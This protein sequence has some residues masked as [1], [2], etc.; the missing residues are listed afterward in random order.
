MV[1][2]MVLKKTN[3]WP[4]L[5]DCFFL[6]L[7]LLCVIFPPLHL[8]GSLSVS[9]LLLLDV[10]G[11]NEVVDGGVHLFLLDEVVSPGLL[12]FHHLGGE[13]EASQLHRYGKQDGQNF[14]KS[15]CCPTSYGRYLYQR[16]NIHLSWRRLLCSNTPELSGC[17]WSARTDL[18]PGWRTH[19]QRTSIWDNMDF[20]DQLVHT[21]WMRK[22]RRVPREW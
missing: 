11:F 17:S 1:L 6:F 5:L 10:P 2:V 7:C 12:Q 8:P 14:I 4:S 21:R 18:Q 3:C 22:P 19:T 20:I 16:L 15:T 13:G 9:S